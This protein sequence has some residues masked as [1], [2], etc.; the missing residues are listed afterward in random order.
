MKRLVLLLIF[1]FALQITCK[2]IPVLAQENTE[3]PEIKKVV[4][5]FCSSFTRGDLDST[6]ELVSK[7]YSAVAPDGSPIDYNTFKIIAS[8]LMGLNAVQYTDSNVT[9]LE[10]VNSDVLDNEA[11][12]KVEY[13][14]HGF[15]LSKGQE[16]NGRGGSA[17][18]LVKEEGSW[19]I[20]STKNLG[21]R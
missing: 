6:M 8:V 7:N 3:L 19:K 16:D 15:N 13:I 14:W 2:I 20:R 11:N 10:I 4:E 18:V 5:N 17:M 1:I 9:N 21:L 12:I